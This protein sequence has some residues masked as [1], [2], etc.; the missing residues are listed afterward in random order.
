MPNE[1]EKLITLAKLV[2]RPWVIA[3]YVLAGLLALSVAG[4]I[5]LATHGSEVTIE[6]AAVP[7]WDKWGY[8]ITTDRL[9]TRKCY[10]GRYVESATPHIT[11]LNALSNEAANATT[12]AS[13]QGGE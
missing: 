3:T 1:F 9:R 10:V 2:A 6:S 11:L 4:N 13:A 5:Y 7:I 12:V 8:P